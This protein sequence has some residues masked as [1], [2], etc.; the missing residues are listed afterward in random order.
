MY[1]F[2]RSIERLVHLAAGQPF[3]TGCKSSLHPQATITEQ[4]NDAAELIRILPAFCLHFA[5]ILPA[6][7]LHFACILPAFFLHFSSVFVWDR[8]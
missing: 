8:F 1:Y 5:C 4:E 6:F 3:G 2:K 7:C